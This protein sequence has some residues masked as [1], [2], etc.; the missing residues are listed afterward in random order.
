MSTLTTQIQNLLQHLDDKKDIWWNLANRNRD[1][2]MTQ[3]IKS[4]VKYSFKSNVS[5][6]SKFQSQFSIYYQSKFDQYD[7]QYSE[8]RNSEY[9]QRDQFS[10]QYDANQSYQSQSQTFSNA[11]QLKTSRSQLQIIASSSNEFA[12][13]SKSYSSRFDNRYQKNNR[14]EYD[15][16]DSLKKAW[17][18]QNRNNNYNRDR[19]Q[20]AYAD[21]IE[22]NQDLKDSRDTQKHCEK[23]EFTIDE[24]NKKNYYSYKSERADDRAENL[25]YFFNEDEY[26]IDTKMISQKMLKIHQ[27]R[28]CKR[29]FSFKNKLHQHIR[30]CRK[31]LKNKAL[32]IETFH[33]NE[34]S[35]NRIIIS[36]AK[37][38]LFKDL[39]FRSWHFVTFVARISKNESLNELCANFECIMSLID[40]AYLMKILS[41]ILI[42]DVENSVTIRDI[43]IATHN[44]FEYVTLELFI[45]DYIRNSRSKDIATL[46]RQAHVVNNLRAKFLMSMNILESEKIILNISRRKMILS[47]CE[48]LKID[49]RVISKLDSRVKRV[50]LAERLVTVSIRTIVAV[51]I[52]MK[53]KTVSERD[54]LFQS[55][56]RELNLESKN[57]VMTHTMNVD[58]AAVQICNVTNKSIVI[59]RKTRLERLMKYEKH[60]CYVTDA[61]KTSLTA[62]SF[63]RKT[64]IMIIIQNFMKNSSIMKKRFSNELIAYET[65]STQQQLFNAIE[66]YSFWDKIENIVIK[67]FENEWMSI[68]LKLDVKIEI[69]KMYSMRFKKRELIDETFDRL[70][71]QKKMHWT[72]KFTAHE[73]SMFVIWRQMSNEEK[74]RRVIV[75]IREFNKIVEFDSYS[76]LLQIDIISAIADFKF[77]F[78]VNVAVFYYQFRVRTAD[79]H[80]LIVVFHRE[81]E[82]FFV[83]SMS[84]RNSSAY[85]QR[86]INMILRDLKHCCRA[87]IDDIIIFSATF[88][89]HVEHLF[90]IFQ[91]LFDYDIKLNSCKTFLRFSS[92]V[93]LK[94][95]VDEFELYAVK[96]K[97]AVILN[98]KFSSTLK[99]LKVYLDFIDW[100]RDYVVW[101]AQKAKSL[102]QRKIMLLKESSQKRSARKTFSCKIMFQ[103]IDRELKSFELVQSIFKNSR[104]LIHFDLMRQFLIDVNAFKNEFE[105]FVYHLKRDDM[106]KSTAIEFIVFLSKILIFVEKRYWSIELKIIAMI[107]I[108][109]K[110]HHMIK[111]SKH[112]TIIWIDHSVTASIVKQSKMFT[113][114]T[115]K[116]NLRLVRV[117]MYLS[118]YDLDIRHK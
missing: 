34:T 28:K 1:Y 32:M 104:F 81:Q 108:V 8:E 39:A 10:Y 15:R 59:S 68:I 90:M 113:S 94:Q 43:D 2:N 49:I 18:N 62:D 46:T 97:I 117:D 48:N 50:I 93:L 9:S 116:L 55:V 25:S 30:E 66:R 60:E 14:E 77:I 53:N 40:R 26:H 36:S 69:V 11:K 63:W 44:C 99:V 71:N 70:H 57:D 31:T 6:Q 41:E 61:T 98:W 56:S 83:T 64:A 101:Y 73:A 115:N 12:F 87:F 96:D 100:L 78:V 52:K 22:K 5:Y 19:A 42:H 107:W 80:K 114:N 109:K 16:R 23:S 105:A 92:I 67:I 13:F 24:Q 102:Q 47:L 75:D 118:Q 65:F 106:I 95:H 45:S 86:R 89:Q 111:A 35:F 17:N 3:I 29:E 58:L 85:A 51:F 33:L 79:R 84:F 72:K 7:S 74:K 37:S 21:A 20:K 54:Y 103:S 112:A 110:L 38:D 82:Y 4:W 88:E 76:M 91:R 27:C